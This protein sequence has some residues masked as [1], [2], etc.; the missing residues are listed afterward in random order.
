M[1][2]GGT[3]E[4]NSMTII[5]RRKEGRK[6]GRKKFTFYNYS[7]N[8]IAQSCFIGGCGNGDIILKELPS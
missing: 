7:N 5:K 1:I 4:V 3:L 2:V 8:V 6:E